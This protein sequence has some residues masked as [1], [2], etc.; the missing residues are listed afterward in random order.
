MTAGPA[1]KTHILGVTSL[2]PTSAYATELKPALP[3]R[4]FEPARSRLWWL[5]THLT[6]IT[7][8]TLAIAERWLG[9]G[10]WPALSLLIGC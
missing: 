4:A 6:V 7:L 3:A 2:R 5:P 9:V 1:G 8:G 10:W